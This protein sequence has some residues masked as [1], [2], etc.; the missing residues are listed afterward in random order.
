MRGFIQKFPD[1]VITK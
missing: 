1:W